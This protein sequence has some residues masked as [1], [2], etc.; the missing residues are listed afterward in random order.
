MRS[1]EITTALPALLLAMLLISVLGSGLANLIIA[2]AAVACLGRENVPLAIAM[3][4]VYGLWLRRKPKW[5]L[6]P[7]ALGGIYFWSV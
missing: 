6:A 1:V 5:V 4:G 2:L 7:V 3:F